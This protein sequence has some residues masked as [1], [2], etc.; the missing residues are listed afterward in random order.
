[1]ATELGVTSRTVRNWMTC[2][3]GEARLTELRLQNVSAATAE[4]NDIL[5]E[6]GAWM[7]A[8]FAV[9]VKAEWD[10]LKI[11]DKL[12][13]MEWLT[14]N[15]KVPEQ[16]TSFKETKSLEVKTTYPSPPTREAPIESTAKPVDD[17]P[18]D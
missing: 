3:A 11:G 17:A 12:K 10:S 2:K 14:K 15:F 9:D 5:S 8:R 7:A 13:A 4:I 18:A 6:A 16:K 1:M